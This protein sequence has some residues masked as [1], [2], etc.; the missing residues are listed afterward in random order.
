LKLAIAILSGF[1]IWVSYDFYFKFIINDIQANRI[2]K[3]M[4]KNF[5]KNKD[6]FTEF[7]AFTDSFDQNIEIHFLPNEEVQFY[8][9]DSLFDKTENK[10][11][12]SLGKHSYFNINY[13]KLLDSNEIEYSF[14]SQESEILKQN[15]SIEYRGKFQNKH[16]KELLRYNNISESEIKEIELALNKIECIGLNKT[17]SLITIRYLGHWGESFDYLIPLTNKIDT[18]NWNKISTQF[19]SHHC[20]N[21]LFCGWTDWKW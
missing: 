11:F 13:V 1:V 5:E 20:K 15:W 16:F 18:D 9:Q 3:R 8:L 14:E 2:E 10:E 17:D 12:L 7:L 21:D 4:Q 19:Y 6:L